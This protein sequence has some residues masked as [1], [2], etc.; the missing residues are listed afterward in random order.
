MKW[1]D[2]MD[3]GFVL[4]VLV[5]VMLFAYLADGCGIL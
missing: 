2:F 4:L 5:S 3:W 1:E